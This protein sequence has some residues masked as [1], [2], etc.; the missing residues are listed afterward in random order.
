[1]HKTV[2]I[3]GPS[4]SGKSTIS[5]MLAKDIGF[6][7]MDTGSLVRATALQM[8]QHGVLLPTSVE[9]AMDTVVPPWRL[10][11]PKDGLHQVMIGGVLIDYANELLRNPTFD[12]DTIH[13]AHAINPRIEQVHRE[14]TAL[15]PSVIS[16]RHA[17]RDILDDPSILPL[18]LN[19]TVEERVARRAVYEGKP[20]DSDL[21]NRIGEKE[22]A[23][24]ALGNLISPEDA[25]ACQYVLIRN[26]GSRDESVAKLLLEVMKK[27]KGYRPIDEG[28]SIEQLVRVEQSMKHHENWA[29]LIRQMSINCGVEGQRALRK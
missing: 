11:E 22:T 18:Y 2:F 16:C 23:N 13:L 12:T 9:S 3:A 7:W 4:A 21:M 28:S 19:L 17:P 26:D 27:Y 20:V 5:H 10:I 15:S 24:T 1:M 14:A 29:E 8:L 25:A 6:N